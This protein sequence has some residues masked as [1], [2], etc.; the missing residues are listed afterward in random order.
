MEINRKLNLVVTVDTDHG[1]IYAHSTPVDRKIF[2]KYFRI[3][4][5]VFSNL[6]AQGAGHLIL[7]APRIAMLEL[8]QVAQELGALDGPGGVEAGLVN[9]IHRLTNIVAPNGKGW[10]T[11]PR[12]DAIDAGLISDEDAAEVDNFIAFFTVQSHMAPYADLMPLMDRMGSV[13][14]VQTTSSSCTEWASSLPT[15]TATESSG[16]TAT[17]LSVPS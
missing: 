10:Q 14:G 13:W 2:E 16:E 9:E 3:V 6:A 4:A 1:T 7:G 8:R 17:I 12:D 15:S 5:R 11:M